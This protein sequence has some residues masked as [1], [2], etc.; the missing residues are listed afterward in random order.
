[1]RRQE[2]HLRKKYKGEHSISLL[3]KEINKHDK[4]LQFIY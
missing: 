4:L 1:M 2:I 3:I